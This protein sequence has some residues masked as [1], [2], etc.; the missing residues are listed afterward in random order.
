MLTASTPTDF[1]KRAP[2]TSLRDV[3]AL[4]R[5]DLDHGDELAVGELGA[6]RRAT[7]QGHRRSCLRRG[8]R[9]TTW[10]QGCLSSGFS[11]A[12]RRFHDPDMFRRG[13]AASADQAH[14]G[15]HEFPGVAGH[16]LGRAQVD[17]S[18]LDRSGDSG[19]G[20][21]CQRQGSRGAH[22]LHRVQHGD[23]AYTAVAADDVRS[24]L[25]EL[26]DERLPDRS[27]RGSCRLRRW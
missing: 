25:L 8:L 17:I 20:L 22:A 1:R 5:H 23:R 18:A 14:S 15:R 6:Q 16:V 11:D 21:G 4:R 9:P 27:R 12:Q 7:L 3:D 26:G 10:R 24:P 19:V 13:S 2:S